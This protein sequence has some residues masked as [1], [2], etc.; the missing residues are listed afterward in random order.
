MRCL[1]PQL[2]WLTVFLIMMLGNLN[3]NK[4]FTLLELMISIALSAI[5]LYG[6][7]QGYFVLKKIIL[8]Y[9]QTIR[10]QN[11]IRL[12]THELYS[13]KDKAGKF[14]CANASQPIYLHV[15]KYASSKIT[16]LLYLSDQQLKSFMRIKKSDLK[17]KNLL[18]GSIYQKVNTSSDILYTLYLDL[19]TKVHD[20]ERV[21]PVYSDCQDV[22]VLS[23]QDSLS[24][25][26]NTEKY[27]FQGN[28]SI[29]YYFVANSKRKNNQDLPINSL[30]RYSS[31]LGTQEVLEGVELI[32][33]DPANNNKIN[34]LLNSVDG[35][36]PL[37]QWL[38]VVI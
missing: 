33:V 17:F 12:I 25:N 29:A 38:T 23:H 30:F 14:G 34:I 10:L 21:Y 35:L 4:G 16:P 2:S 11:N 19:D 28:L 3:K 20:L 31:Y 18:P 9:Y 7:F 27:K 32:Q 15:S 22:F 5:L 6:V 26:F 13:I 37:K 36:P 8:N 1:Q 24:S